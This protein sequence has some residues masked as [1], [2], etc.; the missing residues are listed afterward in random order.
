MILV[1]ES[2]KTQMKG[3]CGF[4]KVVLFD[5]DHTLLT[6]SGLIRTA[7]KQTL[8]KLVGSAGCV[9]TF[10]MSGLTDPIIIRELICSTPYRGAITKQIIEDGCSLYSEKI[11]QLIGDFEVRPCLGAVNLL[12]KLRHDNSICLGLQT[13]NLYK[14][15]IAK[16]HA[17]GIDPHWFPV[18]AFSTDC[19]DRN[20]YYQVIIRKVKIEFRVDLISENL[21]F[22][23][24][25]PYDILAAKAGNCRSIAVATGSY[26]IPQLK[27]YEPDKIFV[28]LEDI[29]QISES[30]KKI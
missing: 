5:I 13:G 10:K 19:I 12:E 14:V 23:G 20:K 24:D 2:P 9:D 4:Q 21:V 26:S 22:I 30:I 16:L 3:Y 28:D 25:T 6:T 18:G 27:E 11:E 8:L 15:A 7:F 17:A 29:D 1:R